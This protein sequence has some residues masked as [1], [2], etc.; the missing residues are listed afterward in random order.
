M[1]D[2]IRDGAAVGCK[3]RVP[4]VEQTR[5]NCLVVVFTGITV[6]DALFRRGTKTEQMK[7][8]WGNLPRFFCFN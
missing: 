7:T 8:K 3:F 1:R 2:V 5:V 4:G 6:I